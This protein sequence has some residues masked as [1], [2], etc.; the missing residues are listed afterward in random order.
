MDT[1]EQVIQEV[2]KAVIGKDENIKKIVATMLARGHI[3]L[4]DIPGVGKTNLTL[5]LSKALSLDYRRMQFTSDVLPGD[6]TGYVIYNQ[7]KN[8]FEYKKGPV[9]CNLFLADEINRTSPK[10]QAALLEVME[11]GRTTVDGITYELPK[12]FTVLATQNPYGSAGTQ[13]LPDSQLDRFM[14][15]LSMGY[16]SFDDE[17]EIL[18]R[19]HNTNPLDSIKAVCTPQDIISIQ[20]EVDK[21]FVDDKIYDYIVRLVHETR[22][23][24]MIMQG[25]SPRTSISL[26]KACKAIAF[27]NKRDYV[28]P[29][30][31]KEIIYDVLGH[32]IIMKYDAKIKGVQPQE[33]IGSVLKNVKEPKI[34]VC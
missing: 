8:D 33:I 5:A 23:H 7:K 2:K 25:A 15:R 19:K 22:N 28:V 14:M 32:R 10:T 6:V 1:I 3:L 17:I 26:L 18:K 30:D 31:I 12:P 27:M 9:L 16:P 13:L 4:E 11:E 34:K 24:D 29:S 20:N 21:V